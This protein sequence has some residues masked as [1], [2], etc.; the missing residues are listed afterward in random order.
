[1]LQKYYSSVL[2]RPGFLI[3]TPVF[4]GRQQSAPFEGISLHADRRAIAG[5]SAAPARRHLI[6]L[7]TPWAAEKMVAPAS[8]AGVAQRT[9]VCI[10]SKEHKLTKL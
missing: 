9:E 8:L 4:V 1:M 7:E 5:G 3:S 6:V 2:L 10:L